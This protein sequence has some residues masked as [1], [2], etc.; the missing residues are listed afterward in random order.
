[1]G[2]LFHGSVTGRAINDVW[3]V[4]FNRPENTFL[5]LTKRPVNLRTWTRI[6]AAS[7]IWP[8]GE[9]WPS[10]MHVGVTAENQ[11]RF[12]ERIPF[13]LDTPAAVRWVSLEPLL[14]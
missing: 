8:V 3:N 14:G 10:W 5:F 12:D 9:V 7:K 13:L 4:A 2:D 1:M 11:D 6:A